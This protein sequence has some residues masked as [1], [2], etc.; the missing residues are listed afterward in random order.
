MASTIT[1]II[2]TFSVQFCLAAFLV[3]RFPGRVRRA[4]RFLIDLT[5]LVADHGDKSQRRHARRRTSKPAAQL[6]AIDRPKPPA[7]AEADQVANDV[8]SA[9]VNFGASKTN[10]QQ[11]VTK[12]RQVHPAADLDTLLRYCFTQLRAA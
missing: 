7:A 2:L 6:V 12:A 9:L 8:V 11:I 3:F 10:A 4:L 5:Q 1:T